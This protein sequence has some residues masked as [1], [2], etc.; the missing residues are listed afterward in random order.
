ML[1]LITLVF[2]LITNTL[3]AGEAE[4][5]VHHGNILAKLRSFKGA[6]EWYKKA[7]ELGSSEANY[8]LAVMNMRGYVTVPNI[9]LALDYYIKAAKQ[10]HA[11]A[12]YELSVIY[13]EKSLDKIDYEQHLYWLKKAVQN[14]YDKAI[15][16]LATIAANVKKYPT[17]IG[18]FKQA[19]RLNYAPSQLALGNM[20]YYGIGLDKN[21]SKALVLLN[22]AYEAGEIQAAFPLATLYERGI[23]VEKNTEKAKTLYK[24]AIDDGNES[25]GFNLALLL[26]ENE[27]SG[28]LTI[29]EKMAQKGD[30]RAI[31][32]LRSQQKVIKK[33]S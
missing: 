20:Y 33:K 12:Q 27:E 10:E 28:G 9:D 32:Y 3:M 31:K 26:I 19:V 22:S 16:N 11:K 23:A 30:L 17:A 14:N 24:K 29:M 15:H 4:D 13:S 8:L 25:A 18:L 2:V 21:Y 5:M 7:A 1:R 6:E